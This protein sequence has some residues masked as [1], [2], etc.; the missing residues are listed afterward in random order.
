LWPCRGDFYANPSEWLPAEVNPAANNGLKYGRRHMTQKV[1]RR[2]G[3]TRSRNALDAIAILKA[4]HAKVKKMF[5]Q[6]DKSDDDS[7][8]QELARIICAELT[9][10][11]TLEE[12]IFYPAARAALSDE[13]VLDEADVEHASA[14]ELIAQIE[15]GSPAD[16]KWSAK[17]KVLGEYV[18]H[19]IAEE[20]KEIFPK[21]RKA[22]LDL[23]ELGKELK[24]R[25]D[26]LM[27]SMVPNSESASDEET[28]IRAIN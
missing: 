8:K 26:E 23:K 13:E 20:H 18:Q 3:G 21:V 11:T 6:F 24:A 2:N 25:K 9:V 5:D 12:E 15:D 10:H 19:H 28:H 4:D 22:K 7:E 27:T 1:T 14:K 17:V 16:D